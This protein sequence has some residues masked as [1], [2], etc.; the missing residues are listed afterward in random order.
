MAFRQAD[1][2]HHML[3]EDRDGGARSE[4]QQDKGKF[5]ETTQEQL[6]QHM[7]C[8]DRS[9]FRGTT[10][11]KLANKQTEDAEACSE[12]TQQASKQTDRRCRGVFRDNNT[13]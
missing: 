3:H 12:T 11:D 13:S 8:G 1:L 10:Q 5:K 6:P 9:V 4:T 2:T 7:L